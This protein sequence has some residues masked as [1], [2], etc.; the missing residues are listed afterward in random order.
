MCKFPHPSSTTYSRT[1][2]GELSSQHRYQFGDDIVYLAVIH[3]E[4]ALIINSADQS[5]VDG[6]QLNQG[7]FWPSALLG[8]NWN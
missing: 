5:E 1:L 6:E 3:F 7:T 2:K 4:I 8:L